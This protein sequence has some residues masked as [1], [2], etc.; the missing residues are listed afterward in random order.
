MMIDAHIHLDQYDIDELDRDIEHWR[1]K[2]ISGVIAVSND[3]ASSYK[4]LELQEKYRDF[5]YPCAGFHPERPLP[6]DKDF[7]E[8]QS[9]IKMEHE[10][11]IAIGEIGLPYYSLDQLPHSLE[12]YIDFLA[13]CLEVAKGSNL[14]VA[15]HA[16]HDKA[17][18]VLSMLRDFHIEKAHFHWLK[19]DERIV[20]QIVDAGYFVSVTPE[21]CYRRRDQRLVEAVPLVQLLIETDGP[22]PF[23]DKF[24]S[25][26]TSPL[27]LQAIVSTL[28]SLTGVEEKA[29]QVQLLKNTYNC[30]S[31]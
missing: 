3:L 14:P 16:V 21:V 30:Y 24:S 27:F 11:I 26:R 10:R 7:F 25:I 18:I 20:T 5:V 28:I 13:R 15:L 23:A 29:L 19:A 12:N 4:T 8:W 31:L 22:W 17:A 6:A 1:E 9:L 2:G